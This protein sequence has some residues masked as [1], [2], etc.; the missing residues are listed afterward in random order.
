MKPSMEEGRKLTK[1]QRDALNWLADMH[2][3]FPANDYGFN[4][5]R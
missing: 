1:A 4:P 2:A 3:K 5:T